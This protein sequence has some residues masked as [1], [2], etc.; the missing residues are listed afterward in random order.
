M[1]SPTT[2][3]NLRDVIQD[4]IFGEDKDGDGIP[5]SEPGTAFG[6]DDGEFSIFNT[7][8]QLSA[9]QTAVSL[10]RPLAEQ[11]SLIYF[12]SGMRLNGTDNQAQLRATV[13]AALRSNVTIHT[14]SAVIAPE[15]ERLAWDSTRC[16]PEASRSGNPV[17]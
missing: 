16:R 1:T 9:L 3:P 2:A 12:A 14:I 10:L 6:Q 7:D 8:R 5:D 4:L 17:A 13:N 11:K 15:R